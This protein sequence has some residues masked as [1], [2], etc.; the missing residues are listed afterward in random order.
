MSF[1]KNLYKKYGKQ[2]LDTIA[3]IGLDT[4][5]TASKKVVPKAAE[6]TEEFI[7]NKITEKFVKPKPMSDENSRNFEDIIISP[8]KREEILNELR[9]VL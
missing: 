6:S 4:L 5:K 8:E 2:L 1:V 9:K 7:G 3:K